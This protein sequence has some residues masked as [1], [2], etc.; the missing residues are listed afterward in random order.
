M[1]H[2]IKHGTIA[3][4]LSLAFIASGLVLWIIL[5]DLTRVAPALAKPAVNNATRYCSNF[6]FLNNTGQDVNG[7]RV[8]LQGI[9]A[10]SDAYNGP[11][12]P[13]GLPDGTSGYDSATDVYR[14]NFSG[15]TALDSDL[16]HIGLCTDSP[17]LTLDQQT[18]SPN[19][20]WTVNGNPV[21][22]KPLFTGLQWEWTT[23]SHLRVHIIN[24]QPFTMTLNTLN[25]LDGGVALMLDDLKGDA[26][27]SLPAVMF[28]IDAPQTLAPHSESFFDVFF[29]TSRP[30]R[31]PNAV[32]LLEVNHPYVIQAEIAAEDDP[33]NTAHLYAQG[34]SPQNTLYL[35]I[36][37]K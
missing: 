29:S 26:I 10:V 24:G 18:S 28:L 19:F 25:L 5:F 23:P 31:Q 35:P 33:W 37:E 17:L 6:D 20:T 34:L 13:F 1:P 8:R 4:A 21:S 27:G 11:D 16:V 22:P 7:L 2:S 30:I 3:F 14:L 12:N 36:I 15:G 32:P 9:K